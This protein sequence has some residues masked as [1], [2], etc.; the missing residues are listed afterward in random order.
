M[1]DYLINCL[2]SGVAAV[3][4]LAAGVLPVQAQDGQMKPGIVVGGEDQFVDV[5]NFCGEREIRVALSVGVSNA[6]RQ[7]KRAELEDEATRCPNIVEVGYADA[8]GNPEKELANIRSLAA[9]GYDIILIEPDAGAATIPAMKD[10]LRMGSVV[11]PV[12]VGPNFAGKAGVD[13]TKIVTPNQEQLAAT[14]ADFISRTLKGTG[15]V[16]V[17]GGAPGAPQTAAQEPGWRGVFAKNPGINILEG[18]VISNWDPAYY[19][20]TMTA[21]LSK[22]P[23]IDAMYADYG[24]GVLGALRAF[25]SAGR[26]MV[27]V[28]GLD[29]NGAQCYYLEHKADNPGLQIG[30]TSSW[31]WI[32]RLALRHALAAL[33]EIETTEP[34]VVNTDLL[35]DSTSDDPNLQPTC[36]PELPADVSLK[37]SRLTREQLMQVFK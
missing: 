20:S 22:Y 17:W 8:G 4:V 25:E 15:D 11:I 13:Y 6:H 33:N 23:K 1:Q 12:E 37:S 10:A 9:Q 19:Q 26:P 32:D 34:N 18:P 35:V 14:Y 5:T 30:F 29:A 3:S 7:I 24:A 28:T 31:T 2:T 21:L 36:D 27:P 16:I